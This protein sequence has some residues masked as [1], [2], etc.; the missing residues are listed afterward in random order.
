[1]QASGV[2]GGAHDGVG[3]RA[4]GDFDR[5]RHGVV[6]RR[7]A[8]LVDQRHGA[9]AHVVPDEERV[10][11]AGDDVDNGI[12]EAENVVASGGH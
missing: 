7:G 8:R 12:A 5:R 3:G 4:A 6:D 11:G 2:H 1:M 9:L 10:V